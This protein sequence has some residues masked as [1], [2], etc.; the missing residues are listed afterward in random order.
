MVEQFLSEAFGRFF[1]E[2]VAESVSFF[3]YDSIKII[4]L[5]FFMI[6]AVGYLRTYVSE[7]KIRRILSGK[8]AGIGNFFASIFGAITPFCSCSS[9]PFYMSFLK[10]GVPLGVSLSFLITSPLVNEYVAVIMLATFGWK[11][12]LAYII[13][14]IVI[15]MF[16][17]MIMGRFR[18]EKYLEKG[19]VPTAKSCKKS[20][21]K[22]NLARLRFGLDEA[23]C[24]VKDLWYW[25]LIGVGIGALIHGFVPSEL[26]HSAISRL[27]Y[28][29][30][31]IAVLLGIPLYANC[32]AIIPVA[33]VLFEKGIPLGTALAFMM[34]TAA[35][36]LPEA[37]IL[38]RVMKLKMI[39]IFF[40]IVG[41]AIMITGYVFNILV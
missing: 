39:L 16:S 28:F 32:A 22:N 25:I 18:M 31:P 19:F 8:K 27:S 20:M 12:T 14:G 9:I 37:I 17:G 30:V 21:K 15:G 26:I 24:I 10:A 1:S 40:S 23:K 34:A 35:L 5:L 4:L 3:V 29:A 7:E 6:T 33:L 13:S 38:R 2:R 11:I 36:S 41:L